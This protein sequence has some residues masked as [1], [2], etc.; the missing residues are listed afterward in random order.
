M[1]KGKN[2][3]PTMIQDD[4][5]I[6]TCASLP[7][8]RLRVTGHGGKSVITETIKKGAESFQRPM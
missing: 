8:D 2:V 5:I 1:S 7:F 6:Y 3:T 4:A